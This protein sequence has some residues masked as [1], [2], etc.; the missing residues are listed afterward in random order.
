[1]TR[2]KFIIQLIRS[3]HRVTVEELCAT[4]D[5]SPITIRRDLKQ[6]EGEGLISRVHGGATL[7]FSQRDG[8]KHLPFKKKQYIHEKKTNCSKT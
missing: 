8:Y 4:L 7:P 1:M 5:V 3:K 2:K 6:L